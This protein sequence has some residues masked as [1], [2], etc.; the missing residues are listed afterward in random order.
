MVFKHKFEWDE[1]NKIL[2]EIREGD[3]L[4]DAKNQKVDG[5]YINKTIYPEKVAFDM[6]KEL[7]NQIRETEVSIKAKQ[8]ELDELKKKDGIVLDKQFMQKFEAALARL[9]LKPAEEALNNSIEMRDKIAENL[10]NIK[11]TMG[12]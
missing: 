9:K 7:D 10:K 8:D 11:K 5:S 6:I 2:T 1:K 12:L 3:E 4:V